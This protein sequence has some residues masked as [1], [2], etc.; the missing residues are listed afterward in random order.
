MIITQF[1]L[2]SIIL[3][4][5]WRT[6]I[7][8]RQARFSLNFFLLWVFLWLAILSAVIY[9]N[10]LTGLAHLVGIGRGVDLG[11]YF[12]IIALLYLVYQ[13]FVRVRDLESQITTL[14]KKT[15]LKSPSVPHRNILRRVHKSRQVPH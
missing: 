3:F 9:P 2:S 15:A 11:I 7:S 4:I 13:L 1:L 14:V 6:Y 10:I 8:F 5:L 12:A